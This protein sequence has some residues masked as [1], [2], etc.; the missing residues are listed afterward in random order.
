MV[1]SVAANTF[2]LLQLV[3]ALLANGKRVIETLHEFGIAPTY[4]EV[5]R[6]KVSAAAGADT[7]GLS[8]NM[9]ASDGLIQVI[10]DNF[11]AAINSQNG[12]KQ[13]QALASIFAQ[14]NCSDEDN[15]FKFPRLKQGE[16]KSVALRDIPLS[17]YNGPKKPEVDPYF[18][19]AGISPL[20]LLCTQIL[21]AERSRAEDFRFLKR[22]LLE[23]NCSDFHGFNTNETRIAGQI[24]KP[25]SKI[26]FRHLIDQTP[27]E[28]ST[29]LTSMID[30]E[31]VTNAAG[32]KITIY[33]R[34]AALQCC[35]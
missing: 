30:A 32:Q 28:H 8:L 34:S 19:T 23:E 16:I 27:S 11:D 18:A 22:S 31:K 21:L 4:H 5:R 13:T 17:I 7:N 29:M 33:C 3:L 14:A 35:S 26:T 20:K 9:N 2:S 12:M 15:D 1:T 25:K 24:P 6:F 10:T